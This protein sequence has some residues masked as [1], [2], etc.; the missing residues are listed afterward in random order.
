MAHISIKYFFLPKLTSFINASLSLI[1]T[2]LFGR[3]QQNKTNT[4]EIIL[5]KIKKYIYIER[6][7]INE[8]NFSTPYRHLEA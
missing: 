8:D 3:R 1:I 6:E 5:K 4:I 2:P 7:I